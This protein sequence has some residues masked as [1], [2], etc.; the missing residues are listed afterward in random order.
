[1]QGKVMALFDS[2][3]MREEAFQYSI[4]LAKRMDYGLIVL[5]LLT[6]DSE[7]TKNADDFRSRV[8]S[9]LQGPMKS[10]RQAGV[11]IEVEMRMGDSCSELMKFLAGSRSVHTIVWGGR[12]DLAGQGQRQHWLARMK[13]SLEC[14]VVIPS[15]KSF[16]GQN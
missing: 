5:V 6:P 15:I 14:P 1:M 4:E 3:S 16:S 9:A 13:D 7:E 2:L 8:R 11:R 12:S 10:A